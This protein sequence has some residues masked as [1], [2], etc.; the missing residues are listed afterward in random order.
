M[1]SSWG[2]RIGSRLRRLRRLRPASVPFLAEITSL[3]AGMPLGLQAALS[4]AEGAALRGDYDHAIPA[5]LRVLSRMPGNL[6]ARK[7][8]RDAVTARRR[9]RGRLGRLVGHTC[10][11]PHRVRMVVLGWLGRHAQAMNA[12]EAYL[13]RAPARVGVLRRVAFHAE[14]LGLRHTAMFTLDGARQI[15]R[16]DADVL[17]EL[18][19]LAHEMDRPIRAARL[20]KHASE[21]RP[22]DRSLARRAVDL[23]AARAIIDGRLHDHDGS[24]RESLADPATTEALERD[25]RA[26]GTHHDRQIVVRARIDAVEADPGNLEAVR[27]LAEAYRESEDWDSAAK[28]YRRAADLDPTDFNLRVKVEEM[29]RAKYRQLIRNGERILEQDPGNT[30]YAAWLAGL[31]AEFADFEIDHFRRRVAACPADLDLRYEL[32]SRLFD[33]GV[34][35]EAVREFQQIDLTGRRGRAA[36]LML[37]RCFLAQGHPDLAAHQYERAL[38]EKTVL[39]DAEALDLLYRLGEAREALG[40]HA[41]AAHAYGR[42]YSVDVA[43]RDIADRLNTARARVPATA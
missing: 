36:R 8:L 40:D 3:P 7:R 38:D 18:A 16:H 1:L 34:L 5:F 2:E 15:D 25:R 26:E 27:R 33:A 37:G 43:Y 9:G 28:W 22:S 24:W 10:G 6:W 20:M 17:I 11:Q 21:L 14:K 32:G 41:A 4:R 12:G 23:A 13:V 19:E 42:V 35:D 39:D 31:K 30:D 29:R